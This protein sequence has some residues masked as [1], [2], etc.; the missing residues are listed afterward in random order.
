MLL[1]L[2]YYIYIDRMNG[3]RVVSVSVCEPFVDVCKV[4]SRNHLYRCHCVI[5]TGTGEDSDLCW[6]NSTVA[7][8]TLYSQTYVIKRTVLL[9]KHNTKSSHSTVLVCFY[10]RI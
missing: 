8:F 2:R 9:S 6:K 10:R 7:R 4:L 1:T 5:R 3:I